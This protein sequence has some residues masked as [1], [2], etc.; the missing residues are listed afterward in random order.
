MVADPDSTDAQTVDPN[1]EAAAHE[2]IAGDRFG[3]DLDD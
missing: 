2:H 3:I 1:V